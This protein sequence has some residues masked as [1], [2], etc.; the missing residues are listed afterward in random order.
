MNIHLRVNG[1]GERVWRLEV[2]VKGRRAVR[3]LDADARAV[4]GHP[5]KAVQAAWHT[6]HEEIKAQ[7]LGHV[8]PSR[9]PMEQYLK[10]WLDG[11]RARW[12][13]TT[14]ALYRHIVETHLIPSLG[15]VSLAETHPAV[16]QTLWDGLAAAGTVRTAALARTIC[17]KAF[18]DA[19]RLGVV[20]TNPV[21]RTQAPVQ[22]A[23]RPVE[24]FT[25]AEV[26]RLLRA[27]G[28]RWRPLLEFAAFSGLRRGEI[29]GLH[30]S[31]YDAATGLLA[32]VRS[33]VMVD[34]KPMVQETTKTQAGR[35]RFVLPDR[36]QAALQTQRAWWTAAREA[37]GDAWQSDAG[38]MFCTRNGG[39]LSPRHVARAF[40]HARNAAG[41]PH[42]P[43]HSLR[44]FAVSV[45]LGA[46]VPL[47]VVSKRIGHGSR[48]V[49][50]DTYGHLLK[51]A[52]EKAAQRIDQWL[53]EA[54]QEGNAPTT[55]TDAF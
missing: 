46:G 55:R 21:D 33:V 50:A 19:Y 20:V 14:Y 5:P 39:V 26:E 43:F 12:K 16:L 35:R 1:S 54:S 13:P 52:D 28:P 41:L 23:K 15:R 8:A 47:E 42:Q 7:V 30:W 36:A 4:E 3:T 37:A 45:Q 24:P 34:G 29:C 51:E 6:L 17:R 18:Q 9:Q 49:T 32:V 48:A 44:H 22:A 2:F 40:E 11:G 31:D 10:G 27:A 25:L 38:W 53:A